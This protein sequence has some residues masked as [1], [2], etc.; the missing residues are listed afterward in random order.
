MENNINNEN[1]T[2]NNL[3]PVST[4]ATNPQKPSEN[5]IGVP[6]A[7][8]VGAIIIGLALVFVFMP[9]R[10]W[11]GATQQTNTL[12]AKA[13]SNIEM[14]ATRLGINGDAFEACMDT[15]ETI[16][17]VKTQEELAKPLA[18]SGTPT[19]IL[20]VAS[21]GQQIEIIGSRPIEEINKMID[22]G[23]AGNTVLLTD[24]QKP[25]AVTTLLPNDHIVGNPNAPIVIV[26]YS[27]SDC[28][29][30][31][32]FHATMH[33]IKNKYGDKVAWVYRHY[34]LDSLHPKARMEA[35][36][37]ECVAKLSDETTFWK[38]LDAMFTIN[39]YVINV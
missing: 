27:D 32:K 25:K 11:G 34:P 12:G 16:E 24:D 14:F 36:A 31:Q 30:C 4:P 21:T 5:K 20:I 7:I 38:Y 23:L 10:Q 29:F 26:E 13:Y 19:S 8:I 22:T 33:D 39:S 6:Q 3:P 28:P 15:G 1:N 17:T 9:D 37:S 18:V 35:E 2:D